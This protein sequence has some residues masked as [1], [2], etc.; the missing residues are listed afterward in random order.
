MNTLEIF[1]SLSDETRIRI[2]N[3]LSY[4]PLCVNE[5]I[6]IL[7]MGQSRISR[8][9]KIFLESKLL[10]TV[11]DGAKVYYGI[12]PQFRLHPIYDSWN[13]IRQ[14]HT[15]DT[16]W[17]SDFM[18]QLTKDTQRTFQLLKKRKI[19][20]INFFDKFGDLQE[21]AQNK[22]VDSHFYRNQVIKLVP[23]NISIAIDAGCG[24]GWISIELIKK[25]KKLICIDQSS[26]ILQ[27]AK[28]R[29][30]ISDLKR[31]RFISSSVEQIPLK[32]EFADVM[33]YS[34][35]L[36]HVPNISLALQE[37]YR[38]LKKNGILVIADLEHHTIEEMRKN[39]ADFW[40]GFHLEDLKKELKAL[41][42]KILKTFKG[43]G[44]GKLN[45]IFIKS[46]K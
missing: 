6:E 37:G 14:I 33:V 7:D 11:R 8:H 3:I 18:N 42:F 22:F 30:S 40:L 44:K 17:D 45:C 29:F 19:D 1:K 21:K 16:L 23:N 13:Q 20:S 41:N 34:M 32:K 35:A 15:N 31:I 38:I 26:A 36:H 4:E 12:S 46:K 2:L 5:I 28:E 43:R 39:F 27:K 10:V 9:L 25:V 24:T